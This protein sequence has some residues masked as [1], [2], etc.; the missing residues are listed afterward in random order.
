MTVRN[1]SPCSRIRSFTLLTL[2]S[3]LCLGV[4]DV[5]TAHAQAALAVHAIDVEARTPVSGVTVHLVNEDIGV[6]DTRRTD[7]HGLAE[8]SGLSTAGAYTIFVEESDQYYAARV[9]DVELRSNATRSVTLFLQSLAEF[10]M[11]EVVVEGTQG[12]ANVNRVNAEVSSSMSAATLEELPVEGRNFT[13]SLYRLPNVTPSTGFFS[14]APNVSIN[15]SNGLFTQYLIDGMD[16]NEQFLGGPQFEAP[17]GMMKDVTVLT[18]TYSAEYGRTGNGV[19]NV[20]TKAGSNEYTGEAFYLT[21]PGQPL[22]GEFTNEEGDVLAQRDL[23]GNQVKNGFQRHQGGISL[24]GPIVRDQTFFFVNLEHT[25]DWKDNLLDAPGGQQSTIDGQNQFTYASGRVDHRWNDRWRSTVRLNASRVRIDRQGGGLTGGVTFASAGNTQRRDGVHVALQNTY[26]GDNLVYESNVQYS[27]F[28][29]DFA[30]P[31]N[32]NTPQVVV[33]DPGGTTRAVLGHPGFAFDSVENTIQTQQKATYQLGA[34]TLKAGIDVLLSDHSLTGGGNPNGNYTVQLTASQFDRFQSAAVDPGLMTFELPGLLGVDP[35]ALNVTNYGVELRPSTFGRRQDLIGLYLEDQFS[36]V[37][38]LTVTAGLRYDYDSLSEAGGGRDNG[39]WDNLAPRLSLNYSIDER[40]ALRGGYGIF[41]DKIVYSVVSDALQQST[42][43]DGFKAQLR[44]LKEKSLLP[45]DT[46]IDQVTH[47][48]NLVA[49]E[50][51]VPYLGGPTPAELRADRSQIQSN[52]LR[53]LNPNG[54]ENPETHQ[55]S[56]G[57]QRQFGNEWLGYI[58]L[59]H[60]RTFNLYRIRDLNAPGRF[61]ITLDDLRAVQNDPDR[62]PADLVRTKDE[63]NATRPVDPR[64]GGAQRIIMT[65]TKGEARYWAANVNLVK[66]RG[67]DWYS[68]R[69]SYTLS[70]RRNNTDDINFRAEDANDFEDEWGPS[71]NDRRH[72]ISAIGTVYPTDRLRVTVASLLQS[73][74]PINRVPNACAPGEGS[75]D[76]VCFGTRDLNGDGRSF[77]DAYV[78]NSDRF[79]GASRNSDRLSWSTRFDLSVQY[80]WPIGGGRVVA[81]ADVFNVLNT[82]NL[83]GFA[84]NATQSNQIQ[85]GPPGSDIEEKNAG[86]PRQFQFGVRY[87]F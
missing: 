77:G 7:G 10:E 19:F 2:F 60:T 27:W 52:E 49:N 78:G 50:S 29:W 79:P 43:S 51:S 40:T 63:A 8:W 86:P 56:L 11:D 72:V 18:S 32:P 6:E 17:T 30:D 20:T 84:N 4:G 38:D 82:E 46:D 15:G 14:E 44:E 61:E 3:F 39:D 75:A 47:R 68:G 37:S 64:P 54:Y 70:S 59:I 85:V 25:T 83:S 34:H 76:E 73:G 87:E 26:T 62:T 53:I 57:I 1:H 16:N 48:G 71:I 22:D 65:E 45:S 42:T 9:S 33:Q 24:G 13:Q 28:N 66:E 69:L 80:G 36:P 67:N 58:D 12:V 21:R 23:S 74:Q 35:G 31:V 81:R 41:Y 55:F 5:S